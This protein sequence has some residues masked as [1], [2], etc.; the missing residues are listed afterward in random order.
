[1][2]EQAKV[3]G[4]KG[5]SISLYPFSLYF[6]LTAVGRRLEDGSIHATLQLAPAQSCDS[7]NA[8]SS[9]NLANDPA[10]AKIIGKMKS[11]LKQLPASGS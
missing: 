4:Q 11:L 6:G 8:T 9:K 1:M 2:K 10:Y 3:K 7:Q 5:K